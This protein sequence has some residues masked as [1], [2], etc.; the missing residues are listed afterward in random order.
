MKRMKNRVFCL[1]IAGFSFRMNAQELQT[2]RLNE[3]VKK[4]ELKLKETQHIMLNHP[5]GYAK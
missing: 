5:V 2:I 1:L 4:G 3:P